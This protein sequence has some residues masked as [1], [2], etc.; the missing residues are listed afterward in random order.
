MPCSRRSCKLLHKAQPKLRTTRL[1]L[2]PLQASDVPEVQRI[3]ADPAVAKFAGN[4]IP[5]PCPDDW[6][7]GWIAEQ[8]NNFVDGESICFAI[9]ENHENVFLGTVRLEIYGSENRA[10]LGYWLAQE[11]WGKG[12]ATEAAMRMVQYAFH[13]LHLQKITGGHVNSQLD[14]GR[15]LQKIGMEPAGHTQQKIHKNG[16]M[17]DVDLYQIF[18]PRLAD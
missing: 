5:C 7:R 2:R 3:V 17:L 12:Y 10:D 1:L 11:Q 4:I 9:I 15:V 8:N 6:S 14:S 16:A 13:D 18:N